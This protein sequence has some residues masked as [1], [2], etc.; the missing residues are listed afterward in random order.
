MSKESGEVYLYHYTTADG[1]RGIV[2]NEKIWATE[3]LYLND[4]EEYNG[5]IKLA[6]NHLRALQEEALAGKNNCEAARL[7]WLI[8]EIKKMRIYVCSFSKEKDDLS[9]WRAYCPKG[10]FAIGFPRS[11]LMAL[12]KKPDFV[13]KECIYESG[14]QTEMIRAVVDKV[15]QQK[16]SL[17][18]ILTARPNAESLR[19]CTLSG[20]LIWELARTCPI[21]KNNA[22]K[23]EAEWRII[24]EPRSGGDHDQIQFRTKNGMVVPYKEFS[25]NDK[26]L[27]KKVRVTVGPT[28]HPEESR[29][30]VY[31]LLRCHTSCAHAVTN[32]CAS[33]RDW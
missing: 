26:E 23:S 27:W 31:Q 32:T 15:M 8:K 6:Q 2:K 7:D 20:G 21:L 10:G 13:L 3:V 33:Y 17:Q 4:S 1:L 22:F 5:G 18:E 24:S 19:K 14:K 25:L 28:P 12:A 16:P 30:S 11:G 29:K 9:Q